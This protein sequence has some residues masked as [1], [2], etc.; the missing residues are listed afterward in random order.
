VGEIRDEDS[1]QAEAFDAHEL[2]SSLRVAVGRL[3]RRL[4]SEKPDDELSDSQYSVLFLLVRE[5]PRTLGQ[6]SER[7]RVTPPSMNRTV[8]RLVDA[9]YVERESAPDDGR[10]VVL[11]PTTSGA[12]LV[13]ETRRR[14]DA[15]LNRQITELTEEE[16][17]I[18]DRATLIL[19]RMS[20]S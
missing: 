10:K 18:L 19:R 6:L 16:S 9:G 14:R 4:R 1:A 11:R 13:E 5:G 8:G 17:T 7:E 3:S 20:D 2:S 15:W 12:T